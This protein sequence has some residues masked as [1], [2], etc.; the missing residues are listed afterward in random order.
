MLQLLAGLAGGGDEYDSPHVRIADHL[1][2]LTPAVRAAGAHRRAEIAAF[3]LATG[4]D[5]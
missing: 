1:D 4:G 3:L 5:D 2:S